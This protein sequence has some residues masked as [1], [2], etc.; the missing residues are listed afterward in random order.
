MALGNA[1]DFSAG[2]EDTRAVS[3]KTTAYSIPNETRK[4]FWDGILHNPLIASTLPQETEECAKTIRFEGTEKPSIPINWR[5]AE[6]IAAL[7]G[8]EAALVNV[9]LKK[10]Y[11]L[12]PQEAV[13]NT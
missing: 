11:G 3:D 6:S 4:V 2:V 8:L 12:K 1:G 7:K 13:I 9:L 5:F 10:K